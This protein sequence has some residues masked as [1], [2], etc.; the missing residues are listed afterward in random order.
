MFIIKVFVNFY[1][2]D[3]LKYFPLLLSRLHSSHMATWLP[4]VI[5]LLLFTFYSPIVHLVLLQR[6]QNGIM[7]ER[8]PLWSG[9]GTAQKIWGKKKSIIVAKQ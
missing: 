3:I 1:I 2:S 7:E 4:M 8:R 9:K 6:H 5:P